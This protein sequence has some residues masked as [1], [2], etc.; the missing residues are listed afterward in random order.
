MIALRAGVPLLV[1][2]LM[3]LLA[4]RTL[5][6]IVV[7]TRTVPASTARRLVKL[8]TGV[9]PLVLLA[10]VTVPAA[11]VLLVVLAVVAV[12]GAFLTAGHRGT[13]NALAG[14]R[15]EIDDS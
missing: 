4:G 15:L 13:S 6:E 7:D 12:A 3:V 14:L 5:G 10:V 9:V 1:E 8:L 2:G 11:Q